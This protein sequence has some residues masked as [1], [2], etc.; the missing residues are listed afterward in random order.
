M[1]MI[2]AL[3]PLGELPGIRIELGDQVFKILKTLAR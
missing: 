1:A 3:E 2:I